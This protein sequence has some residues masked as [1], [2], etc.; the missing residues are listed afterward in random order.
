L[1]ISRETIELLER[2][3][4]GYAG[5]YRIKGNS[6][7][8]MYASPNLHELSG[9][10]AEEFERILADDARQAL[11]VEDVPGL[12]RVVNR[13]LADHK[14]FEHYCRVLHK[15]LGFDWVH[16]NASYLGE[17]EGDAVILAL[18]SNA[19]VESNIYLRIID[20]STRAGLHLR[21]KELR[22]PLHERARPRAAQW[23]STWAAPATRTSGAGRPPAT[24]AS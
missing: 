20:S 6:V 1:E 12:M 21:S 4:P 18:F 10:T 16:G 7:H 17:Y 15:T 11:V 8:M 22:D 3:A 13:C 14:P 23:A 5:I 9:M 19:S 2:V 24:T